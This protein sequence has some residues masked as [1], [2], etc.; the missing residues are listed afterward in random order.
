MEIDKASEQSYKFIK[1]N[2]KKFIGDFVINDL[3]KN[4]RPM[5]IFMA[6]APG[7]GKTEFSKNLIKALK[8]TIRRNGVVRIDADEIRKIFTDFG[9]N[10]KNSDIF[11]HACSKGI[12]ILYDYCLKNKYH[13]ILDGTLSSLDRAKRNIDAALN[14]GA[15]V[16][17]IYVYQDPMVAWGFTKVRE[18]EEGRHISKELFIEYLFNSINSVNELKKEY[19]D[20]IEVWLVEKNISND[21]KNIQ[22]DI[23]NID[24]HLQM[25]Y[26]IEALINELYE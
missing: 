8:G 24:N 1:K 11:K 26:T 6:G 3:S 4:E 21:V 16:F 17:V 9:Y 14:I 10:G 18:K 12:E 5:F 7:A 2:K 25:N 15:A 13:T 20:K 23:D 22:Y 19:N